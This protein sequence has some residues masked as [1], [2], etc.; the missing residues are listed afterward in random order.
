MATVLLVRHGRTGANSDGTLAGRSP[1]VRLDEAGRD[2]AKAV[3]ARL[4]ALPLAALVTSPLLR[5][6]ETAVEIRASQPAPVDLR[7]DKRLVECGYGTWTG[8]QLKKL[9]KDPLWRAVQDHPSSVT[10][11][12]GESMRDMQ[13]RAVT[14]IRDWDA[15]V[16][17]RHGTEAVWAAVS[18][19]DVIKAVVADA[20]AL[21]LD[22]FQRIVVDPAS[23]TVIRFTPLRP[24]VVRLNDVGGDLAAF[25]P[26]KRR[27]RRP[28]ASDAEVGGGAGPVP[29]AARRG[30]S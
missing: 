3:A 20:L 16:Q 28:A 30:R 8:A 1:G 15:A 23:V 6:R 7:T 17:E 12:D 25:R 13:A 11:P 14:A 10:F 9:A 4:S 22:Q 29:P 26:P 2:Q 19:G 18:H 24:F 21:H 5:C 27:R